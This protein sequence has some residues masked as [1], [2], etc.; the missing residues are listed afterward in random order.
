MKHV[1]NKK[2]LTK[3]KLT[4]HMRTHTQEKPFQC[5]Y[6]GEKYAHRHNL[7]N[8]VNS[9]HGDIAQDIAKKV[10]KPNLTSRKGIPIGKRGPRVGATKRPKR[11]YNSNTR[12]VRKRR[13]SS[14]SS[15]FDEDELF[16]DD[17]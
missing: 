9:K 6:C 8:H 4:E 5:A 14:S 3:A 12:K 1:I 16:S 10:Y 17:E 15:D 13:K 11:P 2:C 7:R